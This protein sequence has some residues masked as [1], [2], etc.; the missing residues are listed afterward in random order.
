MPGLQG[1]AFPK[2]N[3]VPWLRSTVSPPST[4]WRDV[5]PGLERHD[6]HENSLRCDSVNTVWF[7]QVSLGPPTREDIFQTSEPEILAPRLEM[8]VK[9]D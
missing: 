1:V 3:K 2:G 6:S 5:Q 9:E 8:G 4:K 7:S